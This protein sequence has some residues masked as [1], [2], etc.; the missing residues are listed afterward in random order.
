MD[1]S[2][3]PNA[4]SNTQQIVYLGDPSRIRGG[5]PASVFNRIGQYINPMNWFSRRV[6]RNRY[7][8][9]QKAS[10]LLIKKLNDYHEIKLAA[11]KVLYLTTGDHRG[12]IDNKIKEELNSMKPALYRRLDSTGNDSASPISN[13]D[14]KPDQKIT[15][16]DHELETGLDNNTTILTRFVDLIRIVDDRQSPGPEPSD[17]TQAQATTRNWEDE[18]NTAID[19]LA[20]TCITTWAS[21]RHNSNTQLAAKERIIRNFILAKK[22]ELDDIGNYINQKINRSNIPDRCRQIARLN[23]SWNLLIHTLGL[24]TESLVVRFSELYDIQAL[25]FHSINPA[26]I[27]EGKDGGI[28]RFFT[29]FMNKDESDI[30]NPTR[31][32]RVKDIMTLETSISSGKLQPITLAHNHLSEFVKKSAIESTLLP[33]HEIYNFRRA[34]LYPAY[35]FH[36]AQLEGERQEQQECLHVLTLSCLAFFFRMLRADLSEGFTHADAAV[37]IIEFLQSIKSDRLSFFSEPKYHPFESI[38][39]L[40]KHFSRYY[41]QYCTELE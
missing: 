26:A 35:G 17:G 12:D 14:S 6:G 13:S 31:A 15:M 9:Y 1:N 5:R 19:K 33:N 41:Y 20:N 4:A 39:Q 11:T 8:D 29:R 30:N 23:I 27:K 3:K 22:P 37:Q 2:M 21:I 28:S 16:S 32:E 7:D 24:D 18:I 38:E 36:K 25:V 10:T 34:I 40:D